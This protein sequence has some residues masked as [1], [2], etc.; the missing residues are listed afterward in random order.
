MKNKELLIITYNTYPNGNAGAVRQHIFAK[1]FMDMGFIVNLIGMGEN[2]DFKY[3]NF[4][5]VSYISLRNK[6][7]DFINKV[8][9]KL[10][11][12]KRLK[13]AMSKFSPDVIMVVDLPLSVMNYTRKYAKRIGATLIHDSV[14]WYSKE[15]FRWGGLDLTYIKKD[16]MNR[17]VINKDYNVIAISEY[18]RNHFDLRGIKTCRIPFVQD[19]KNI[20]VEKN[21]SDGKFVIVYAG[22]MGKKDY[23]DSIIT[24]L[25]Q[26]D[27]KLLEKIEL[28]IIGSN[29]TLFL[30]YSGIDE[31][32]LDKLGDSVKFFGRI[33][34][35][36]V[37]EN[38]KQANFTIIIR[39]EDLRYAKAGFPTKVTESLSYGTP[40][41]ANL[42][43]DL[44]WYLEDGYNS[45]IVKGSDAKS[46]KRALEKTL[47]YSQEQLIQMC[48]NAR[49]TAEEKLD[50]RLF[51]KEI[52]SVCEKG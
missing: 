23:F 50:Y 6:K 44:A 37:L 26:L 10:L 3:K 32:L 19:V 1:A 5:G 17:K 28:R 49:K 40:V 35:E 9:T 43:S 39:P 15:E 51:M 45:V 2:T 34:R 8:L 46:V 31:G 20:V 14:E 47:A 30:K 25:T 24:A 16:I 38:L 22:S 52:K 18:L 48:E 21:L 13:K 41:I 4:E 29:K 42:T 36:K 11:Y 7:K 12:K 33:P 27:K